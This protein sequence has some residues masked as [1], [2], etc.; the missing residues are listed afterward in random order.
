MS[1]RKAS[2]HSNVEATYCQNLGGKHFRV[3]PAIIPR[4]RPRASLWYASQMHRIQY[5]SWPRM[6]QA[7]MMDREQTAVSD[8]STARQRR[9]WETGAGRYYMQDQLKSQITV[10]KCIIFSQSIYQLNVFMPVSQYMPRRANTSCSTTF[11][12]VP[13]TQS[14][15][16]A[17]RSI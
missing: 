7:A 17:N 11:Q 3:T 15:S 16:Q 1:V 6:K 14:R 10:T 2:A 12:Q 13:N 9:R 4:A 5:L 8:R